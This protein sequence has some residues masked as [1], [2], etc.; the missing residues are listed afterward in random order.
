MTARPGGGVWSEARRPDCSSCA[1]SIPGGPAGSWGWSR[2]VCSA[3][4]VMED[5]STLGLMM[6]ASLSCR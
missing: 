1:V 6:G 2:E 3:R 5:T 4:E